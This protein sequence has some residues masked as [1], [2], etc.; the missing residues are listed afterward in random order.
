MT[1]AAGRGGRIAVGAETLG[2]RIRISVTE[3]DRDSGGFPAD[4]FDELRTRLVDLYGEKAQLSIGT[5]TMS[6]RTIA[7]EIPAEMNEPATATGA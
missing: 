7:L 6:R 5:A 2:D 3:D 1:H 4:G